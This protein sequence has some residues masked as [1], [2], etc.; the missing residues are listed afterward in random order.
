MIYYYN[1]T[2]VFYEQQGQGP[3]LVLLHGFLESSTIWDSFILKLSASK[4]LITIDLPGHGKSGCLDTVHSM[5]TMAKVV[6]SVLTYLDISSATFLGH[7]MGGYVALAYIEL[8]EQSVDRIILLNS[9]TLGDS[10][11]RKLNRDRALKLIS[12][13]KDTFISMAIN[14]LFVEGSRKNYA[15]VI[16][17]LKKEA[18]SF[19]LEGINAAIRGMRNRK[20][21]TEVLKNFSRKKQIIC[22]TDDPIVPLSSSRDIAEGTECELIVLDGGHMIWSEKTDECVKIIHL[23]D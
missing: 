2:P 7:S 5:E 20:D 6:N 18:M 15:S 22:G 4:T 9:T 14:N 21:R 8:F 13:N 10:P 1:Q 19:P 16:E 3:V 17:Q 11:E 23:I 12:K